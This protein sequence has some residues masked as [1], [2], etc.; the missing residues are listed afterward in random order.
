[1]SIDTNVALAKSEC[2]Q[3]V[4][5]FGYNSFHNICTGAV[6]NLHWGLGDWAV[7]GVAC[8]VSF[9]FLLM[10]AFIVYAIWDTHH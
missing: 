1:M 10:M 2:I 7:F 8:I 5:H 3:T 9:C 4:T 6:M